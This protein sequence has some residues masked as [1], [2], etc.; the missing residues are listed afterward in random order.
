MRQK[1]REIAVLFL[2]GGSKFGKKTAAKKARKLLA[3]RASGQDYE[4][5]NSKRG[6]CRA[7]SVHHILELA[8]V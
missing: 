3:E 2:A 4:G 7:G 5:S 1:M 6:I 8:V